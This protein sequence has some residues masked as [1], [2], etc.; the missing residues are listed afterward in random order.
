ML[1]LRTLAARGL[2]C[3]RA[4]AAGWGGRRPR[5]HSRHRR[6]A[7]SQVGASPMESDAS[8]VLG[9]APGTAH[10]WRLPGTSTES[11]ASPEGPHR[12]E[13]CL[14]G[15]RKA[16]LLS[17]AGA[18]A[19]P[20]LRVLDP[21]P[22]APRSLLA[23][24]HPPPYLDALASITA[25]TKVADSDDEV[26]FTYAGPD[27]AAEAARAAGCVAAVVD[28]VCRA[29]SPSTSARP[30]GLALVRPPGHHAGP[31]SGPDLRDS[32]LGLGGARGRAPSGFCL[33]SNVALGAAHA[34]SAWDLTRPL[35]VDLD[36]HVGDGTQAALGG[37][38]R[39]EDGSGG[40][41]LIIDFHQKG[42]WPHDTGG[43]A[44][45]GSENG[46][47]VLNVPLTVGSG[48]AAA[49]SAFHRVI[50]PAARAFAPDIIFVSLGLDA[51]AADPLGGLAWRSRTFGA[52]L[53]GLAALAADLCQGRLV[54]VLEGG[55]SA[56]GLERG[57]AAV[58][59][60]LVKGPGVERSAEEEAADDGGTDVDEEGVRATGAAVEAA[61]DDVVAR[62]GLK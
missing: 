9:V 14:A 25:P 16:G 29:P 35:I 5:P 33:L 7:H 18:P 10:A 26:E 32:A 43:A 44:D 2:L 1:A 38:G 22:P 24:I 12:I 49:R 51:H 13:H 11:P 53:S 55:Y 45:V 40:G 42:V 48:D 41:A 39:G 59:R 30:A 17:G 19:H 52:L 27:S 46:P 34:R 4:R 6:Q 54:V 37:W 47:A 36:V 50:A 31:G 61:L 21:A 8:L 23:S 56:V 57:I 20:N 62:H 58:A 3:G 28:A 15:L 60:A